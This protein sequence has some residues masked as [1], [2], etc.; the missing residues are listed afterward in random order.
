MF[1]KVMM[2]TSSLTLSVAVL[3]AN[4]DRFLVCDKVVVFAIMTFTVSI[5]ILLLAC[6]ERIRKYAGSTGI[7][8]SLTSAKTLEDMVDFMEAAIDPNLSPAENAVKVL[9]T[10]LTQRETTQENKIRL[11][12]CIDVLNKR[13]EELFVP[14]GLLELSRSNS[15]HVD[16]CDDSVHEWLISQFTEVNQKPDSIKSARR[17]CSSAEASPW[18]LTAESSVSVSGSSCVGQSSPL[19]Q[20][21]SEIAGDP[22]TPSERRSSK[23]FGKGVLFGC[24]TDGNI[25]EDDEEPLPFPTTL[26]DQTKIME[27]LVGVDEWGWDVFKLHAVSSGRDLQVLG[28]HI[29]VRWD[30]INKLCLKPAVVQKWLLY[31]ESSYTS[32]EYHNATHAADVLQT[33]HFMLK[34]AGAAAFL[35]DLQIFAVLVAAMVHDVAHDG[36]TN[37][38]HKHLLTDRALSFNDQSIQE[39]FHAWKV[40]SRMAADKEINIFQSLSGEQFMELRRLLITMVHAHSPP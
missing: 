9:E 5:T 3:Y 26:L 10:V 23:I 39:N 29:F 6:A 1:G 14:H 40:F 32:A 17:R 7:D 34:S 22:K 33:V 16:G 27:T 11:L 31:V 37:L 28:W 15:G 21:S 8:E 20:I 36:F 13:P 18:S 38:Y 25:N 12:Y 30:L 4:V 2:A 24:A 35:N 19:R